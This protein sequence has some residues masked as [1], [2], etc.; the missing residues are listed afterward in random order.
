[1]S[2]PAESGL[3]VPVPT[4]TAAVA[5]WRER[6]DPLAVHGVPAHVT[7]LFPF[8]PPDEISED[9]VRSLQGLFAGVAPFDFV[10]DRVAWF[11]DTVLYLAPTPAAPFVALTT[12]VQTRFPAYAPYEGAY[13]DVTPH[14][15]VGDRGGVDALRR[16]EVAV[17]SALP[18]AARASDVWLMTGSATAGAWRVRARF[19]FDGRARSAASAQPPTY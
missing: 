2:A 19:P 1:M 7:V 18:I 4:A 9:V 15:T 10:L 17:A 13:D 5:P 3:V 11:G 8:V 14:V 16:A 12:L 6:L